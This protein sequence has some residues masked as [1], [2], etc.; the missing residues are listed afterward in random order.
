MPAS[1]PLDIMAVLKADTAAQ[2]AHVETLM[3][4]FRETFSLQ[5][6]VRTLGVF[7]GFFEPL[8]HRLAAVAGWN[9]FGIDL[10]NRRRAHLLRTDLYALGVSDQDIAAL[11][12]C[13]RLP[14]LTNRYIG[15]GCLYVLEGSTLGGQLISRELTSR[16]GI[17]QFS[18]TSFFCSHGANVGQAWKEFGSSVR[19]HVNDPIKEAATVK[20]AEETFTCFA[21]WIEETNLNVD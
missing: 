6:Y 5:Q 2:H 15:L 4:F 10:R 16:F 20:A 17:E 7:L 9:A 12:R 18:G 13:H 1:P 19:T 14:H 8:E 3:P 21:G 11:P